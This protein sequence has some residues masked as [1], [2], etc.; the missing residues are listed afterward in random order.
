MATSLPN[1]Q[2]T[3]L[4]P[5]TATA[6]RRLAHRMDEIEFLLDMLSGFMQRGPEIADNVGAIVVEV[7]ESYEKSAEKQ[8]VKQLQQSFSRLKTLATPEQISQ[9]V[10]AIES[11]SKALSSPE[12]QHFLQKDLTRTAT[13]L[14]RLARRMEEVEFLFNMTSSFMQRGPEIADNISSIVLDIRDSFE[15]SREKQHLTQL[16]QIITYLKDYATLQKIEQLIAAAEEVRTVL[17]SPQVQSLLRSS[18]LDPEAV[19]VVSQVA[20]ALIESTQTAHSK[21][22]KLGLMGLLKAM[23]DPDVQRTLGFAMAFAKTF[24]QHL[25]RIQNA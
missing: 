22:Q 3:Q 21:P 14:A 12:I 11:L 23:R 5:E 20:E 15:H 25:A 2:N 9:M 10:L 4:D 6:L 1:G 7:R 18:V 13:T 19:K 16:R 24:G 17:E 8:Q